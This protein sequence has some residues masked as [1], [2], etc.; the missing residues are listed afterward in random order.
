MQSRKLRKLLNN[1]KYAV[2]FRDGKVCIG[3][4]MCSELITVD[5]KT[6]EIKY[7]LDTEGRKTIRSDELKFIWDKLIE[8]IKNGEIKT[9]VENNDSTANMFPVYSHR[10]GEIIKQ[11]A[12]VFGWPNSTHDG[13]LMYDN[14]FFKTE[15]EAIEYGIKDLRH[16]MQ[17]YSERISDLEK[18]IQDK[19]L[20]LEK[21][22]VLHSKLCGKRYVHRNSFFPVST[23]GQNRSFN[24][25]YGDGNFNGFGV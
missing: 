16:T 3:S 18:D 10:E 17:M 12:D 1:T 8:L 24:T 13:T 4:P 23:N 25:G 9:I 19:K 15:T 22:T 2:H 14:T 11:F 7:T 20:K 5:S 21:Y 6:F